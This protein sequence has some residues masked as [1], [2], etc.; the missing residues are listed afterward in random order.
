MSPKQKKE[1]ESKQNKKDETKRFLFLYKVVRERENAAHYF[2]VTVELSLGPPG[3]LV[4]TS[5]KA[6]QPKKEEEG[7]AVAVD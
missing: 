6:K 5:I 7:V 3:F 1:W 4:Y 2:S